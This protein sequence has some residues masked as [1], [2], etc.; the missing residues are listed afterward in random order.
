M[1]RPSPY[2]VSCDK[3]HWSKSFSP[4]SDVLM[5]GERPKS[6]PECGNDELIYKQQNSIT[7]Y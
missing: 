3:C 6:C 1:I 7:Y 4:Q 5:P 2:N